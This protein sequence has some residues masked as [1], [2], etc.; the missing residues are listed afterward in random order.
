MVDPTRLFPGDSQPQTIGMHPNLG[1]GGGGPEGPDMENRVSKL[2]Q[3]FASIDKKLDQL[4]EIK[5][6]TGSNGQCK[7][8]CRDQGPA[9]AASQGGRLLE[10]QGRRGKTRRSRDET[11]DEVADDPRAHWHH[12][13]N[14]M[15]N[16][17]TGH[18]R[19]QIH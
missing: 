6:S 1:G 10:P 2:E 19:D 18:C 16:E 3:Q 15:E 5:N 12:S 9:F 13:R 4:A 14:P 8:G 7:R 17:I 11:T